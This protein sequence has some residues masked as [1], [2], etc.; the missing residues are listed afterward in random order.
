MSKILKVKNISD[1]IRNLG[2]EVRHPLVGIVDYKAV[3]P[4]PHS[5]NNYGI[6]GVF[7][8]KQLSVEI[9]YGCGKYDYKT[10]GTII[11]VAPGQIG[12]KEDNGERID[13]DGWA[14]LFHPDFL[15]NTPLEK[16]IGEYTFFDYNTNEALHTT[17]E[18]YDTLARLMRQIQEELRK[19]HDDMQDDI[20][21]DYISLTL[22]Y[23]KR[24]Y[25]R[26]FLTRKA[27]N[28][29]IL[30]RFHASLENYYRQEQQF[31]KGLPSVSYCAGKLCLSAGYFGDLVKKHTGD[32]AIGYIHQF[33]IQKAKS[34][35]A[36]GKNISTVAYDLGFDFPGHFSRLFKKRE[37]I[38]PS[39]YQNG[40]KGHR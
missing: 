1:Y 10:G 36:S 29:D 20:I 13:L 11:C 38:S 12:G 23:C 25:G 18:E 16:N 8:H 32:S 15:H 35:L 27:E 6:Y 14:L 17:S 19:R 4:I 40:I 39:E 5:L 3:S 21:R 28:A 33:I 7:M 31:K 9:T 26:Q 2:G 24:F 30:K 34:E 22:N 37:G